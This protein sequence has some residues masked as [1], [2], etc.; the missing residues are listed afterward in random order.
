MDVW[1]IGVILFTLL[2]GSKFIWATKHERSSLSTA[3][4]HTLGWTHNPQPWVLSICV[5][6]YLREATMATLEHVCPRYLFDL[7]DWILCLNSFLCRSYTW[8]VNDRPNTTYDTGRDSSAP[9]GSEA[10]ALCLVL[11][12]IFWPLA[13]PSQLISQNVVALAEKLTESLRTIGDLE[14]ANPISQT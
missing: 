5:R 4:R 10:S 12:L 2:L 6:Y 3:F 9:L 11:S 1:G 8:D 7:M 14:L 13:R